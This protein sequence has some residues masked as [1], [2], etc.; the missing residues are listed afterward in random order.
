MK[1]DTCLEKSLPSLA[2]LKPVYE[3]TISSDRRLRDVL[4]RSIHRNAK[5]YMV[6][7]DTSKDNIVERLG[8][9]PELAYDLLCLQAG[10]QLG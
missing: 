10:I 2:V 9:A 6:H 5:H 8:A 3:K 7:A 4:V 1:F